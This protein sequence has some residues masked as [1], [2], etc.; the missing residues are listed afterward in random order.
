MPDY[1]LDYKDRFEKAA[2]K[3]F[4]EPQPWDHAV[5]TKP[6]FVPRKCGIIP[7]SRAEQVEMDKFLDENLAMGYLQESKSPMASPAFF[8]KKKDSGL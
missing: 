4:P 1:L 7:L 8:V 2:A 3:R 6:D 5:K